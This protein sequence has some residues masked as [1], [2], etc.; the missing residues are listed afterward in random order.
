VNYSLPAWRWR[1]RRRAAAL[2][3]WRRLTRPPKWRQMAGNSAWRQY[4][5]APPALT[6]GSPILA[7]EAE[8]SPR[9]LR[10][11]LRLD[12]LLTVSALSVSPMIE[13]AESVRDFLEVIKLR[14]GD[15]EALELDFAPQGISQR[16][17][18]GGGRSS[19]CQRLHG[20]G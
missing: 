18:C 11:D 6:P 13:A 20:L 9:T 1:L 3:P 14:A 19:Q 12:T 5:S 2:V 8:R 15:L 16:G 4:T 17:D 10:Q 7:L